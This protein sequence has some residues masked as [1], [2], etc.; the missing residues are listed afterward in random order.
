MAR[1]TF[2]PDVWASLTR[3]APVKK[4]VRRTAARVRTDARALAPKDT[5][6]GAKSIAVAATYDRKTRQAGFKVTWSRDRF[7]MRFYNEGATRPGGR[8][9]HAQQFLQKAARKNQ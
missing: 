4:Q 9:I 6:A 8:A 2:H 5:G 3:T 7:Y 1:V